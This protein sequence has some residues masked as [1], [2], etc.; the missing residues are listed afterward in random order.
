[1]LFEFKD[2]RVSGSVVKVPDDVNAG[3]ARPSGRGSTCV[4]WLVANLQ[5]TSSIIQREGGHVTSEVL[6]EG[7]NGQYCYF[8]DPDGNLGVIYQFV[9]QLAVE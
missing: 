6:I 3:R 1:M 2:P 4:W 9:G 7:K 5:D 8:E